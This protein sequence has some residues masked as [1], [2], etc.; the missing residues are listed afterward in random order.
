MKE[1][2]GVQKKNIMVYRERIKQYYGIRKEIDA[3]NFEVK[4]I[5]GLKFVC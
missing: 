1:Y 5:F 3:N 2:Y 4:I